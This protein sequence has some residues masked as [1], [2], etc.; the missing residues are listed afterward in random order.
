MNENTFKYHFGEGRCGGRF[1]MLPQFYTYSYSL[2]LNN[3]I[4]VQLIGKQSYQVTLFRYI[5]RADGVSHLVRGRKV[6]GDKKYLMKSVKQAA[7]AIIIWTE[8]DLGCED[9]EF[10]INHGIW[11]VQLKN[12]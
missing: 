10:I 7:E 2:C 4:Q 1:Y 3:F 11:E 12:K 9:S 6:L 5:T 8:E